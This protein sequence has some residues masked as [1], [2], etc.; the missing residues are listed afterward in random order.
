MKH[1]L[2]VFAHYFHVSFYLFLCLIVCNFHV[3][4]IP[5]APCKLFV[6]SRWGHL[7]LQSRKQPKNDFKLVDIGFK[8]KIL[9]ILK[10]KL[11]LLT[12]FHRFQLSPQGQLYWRAC[13]RCMIKW[14]SYIYWWKLADCV[15]FFT[16]NA[17]G[18]PVHSVKLYTQC[19]ISYQHI[20]CN[21]THTVCNF[22]HT[23]CNFTQNI[24]L[25]CR[26]F[27]HFWV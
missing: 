11:F 17:K 27:T 3:S 6:H 20:V 12:W 1:A 19:V 7:T 10:C 8:V 26:K 23:V 18:T 21:F 22:T 24:E 13:Q 9:N 5:P 25:L 2:L 15:E 16:T 4:L 14:Q